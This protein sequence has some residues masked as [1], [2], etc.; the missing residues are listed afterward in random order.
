[1]SKPRFFSPKSLPNLPGP[2]DRSGIHVWTI[3]RDGPFKF[4]IRA[5]ATDKAENKSADVTKEPIIIDLDHPRVDVI[6]IE[7]GK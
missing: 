7:P 6:G 3:G 1:M 5:T 4:M 2:Q